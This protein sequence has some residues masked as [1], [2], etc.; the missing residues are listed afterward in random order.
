MGYVTGQ[1]Y[2]VSIDASGTE[3]DMIVGGMQDN[4]T[5][6]VNS[7]NANSNWDDIGSGDGAYSAIGNNGKAVVSS[8][9]F[10]WTFFHDYENNSTWNRLQSTG[11]GC[12]LKA[13]LAGFLVS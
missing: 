2:H 10:G 8:A 9:Q 6:K 3:P 5:F 4:S 7:T 12:T 1:F 11:I 13:C